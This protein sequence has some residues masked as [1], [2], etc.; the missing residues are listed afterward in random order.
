MLLHDTCD[1]SATHPRNP[2]FLTTDKPRPAAGNRRRPHVVHLSAN[3]SSTDRLP[4][5]SA[6]INGAPTSSFLRADACRLQQRRN[7][8]IAYSLRSRGVGRVSP[9]RICRLTDAAWWEKSRWR[10]TRLYPLTRLEWI[11][12]EGLRKSAEAGIAK[13][14]RT[15]YHNPLAISADEFDF[16]TYFGARTRA[17]RVVHVCRALRDERSI[18]SERSWKACGGKRAFAG[19]L[20]SLVNHVESRSISFHSSSLPA[21]TTTRQPRRGK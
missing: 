17:C 9:T 8:K 3:T 5:I 10:A 13:V 21:S 1:G 18:L 6:A 19:R 14:F 16:I 12:G 11:A 2:S 20:S 15:L 7:E 4:A